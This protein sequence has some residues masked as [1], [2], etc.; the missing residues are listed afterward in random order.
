ML[1]GVLVAG[2]FFSII[3]ITINSLGNNYNTGGFVQEDIAKYNQMRNLSEEINKSYANID[4]TTVDTAWYDFFSGIFSKLLTPFKF[5]YR[6]FATLISLT[7]H[8]VSDLGL[9]SVVG[10]FLITVVTL[11][12]IIGIVMFKFYMGKS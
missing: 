2:L 7:T 12:V 1:L 9:L 6:S 4:T 11:I 3:G 10:D 8:S 5:I